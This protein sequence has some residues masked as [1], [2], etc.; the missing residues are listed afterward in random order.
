MTE[1]KGFRRGEGLPGRVLETGECAWIIDVTKDANFP[2]AQQAKDIG[3]RAGFAFPATVENRVLS[4]LEFFAE[5]AAAPDQKTLDL[6]ANV[7]RQL[8]GVIER[9][10]AGERLRKI[11]EDSP[12]A[13]AISLDDNSDDDGVI[14]FANSRF[15]ELM[16]FAPEDVG[17]AKTNQFMEKSVARESFE[18]SLGAGDTVR[19][20]EVTVH[21]KNGEA[22][23]TLM[24]ISPITYDDRQSALLWLFDITERKIA[25][26]R[27]QDA[28]EIITGSIEYATHIQRSVLPADADFSAIFSDHFVLWQPRDGVGGDI[29][30]N[31]LWGDGRLVILADCTGHGVPGAF[32][33]LIATGALDRAQEEVAAGDV[34][35]LVQRM[36]QHIQF[37]L[38]QQEAEGTIDDGLDLGA[39]YLAGGHD[40]INF[41]GASFSLF[42]VAESGTTEIKGDKAGIGYRGTPREVNFTT[43]TL[44]GLAGDSFY[45]V[46]DG[47]IDQVGGERRRS[48]GKKR[49]R[50]LLFSLRGRPFAEQS[51]EVVATL[52]AYQGAETRC[53]D[54]SM[55]GFKF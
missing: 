35:G 50:E 11:L 42:R 14:Q 20:M 31:R 29:Y 16:G 21:K 17:T 44:E 3:A 52:E 4:V 26:E 12:I 36:H 22:L 27:L 24:S 37:F 47:I 30:W 53:D 33:T 38:G 1:S 28:Y 7:G 23:W 55:I 46:T 2:R 19:N 32:M 54:V 43:H 9:K 18:A 49:I 34:A 10:R 51:V 25:G 45:L 13:I 41:V 40:S 5:E 8:G 39:C 15:F 6:M 48:F